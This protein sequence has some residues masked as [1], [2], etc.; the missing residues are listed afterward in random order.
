MTDR[1]VFHGVIH[2]QRTGLD[3]P[4]KVVTTVQRGEH[5][6]EAEVHINASIITVTFELEGRLERID[7]LR[8]LVENVVQSVVDPICFLTGLKFSPEITSVLYPNGES[9]TFRVKIDE[10]EN[11]V[12]DGRVIDEVRRITSLYEGESGNYLRR[13]MADFHMALDAAHETGFYCYRAIESIKQNFHSEE[14]STA[15]SWRV[16]RNTLNIDRD[17]ITYI[18]QFEDPRRHGDVRDISGQSR[19]E[20]LLLTRE[21]I[22]KFINYLS[23]SDR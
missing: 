5:Q 10:V 9:Q 11:A 4:S 18:K 17:D 22:L 3:V 14:R 20:M 8:E 16:M 13:A 12:T 6:G 23:E 21:M 7:Y 1:Y 19:V 2:P 15:Q